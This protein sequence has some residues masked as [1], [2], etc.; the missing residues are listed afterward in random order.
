[1]HSLLLRQLKRAAG[2]ADAD[3]LQARVLEVR[4]ALFLGRPHRRQDAV[5]RRQGDAAAADQ[6]DVLA[7]PV[8]GVGAGEDRILEEESATH[9]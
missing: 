3:Q 4:L 2:I 6:G 5:A 8:T 9:R 1:M 7:D